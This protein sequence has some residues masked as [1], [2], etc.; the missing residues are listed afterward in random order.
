MCVGGWVSYHIPLRLFSLLLT[1]STHT[2][3]L[4]APSQVDAQ[5]ITPHSPKGFHHLPLLSSGLHFRRGLPDGYEPRCGTR[6]HIIKAGQVDFIATPIPSHCHPPDRHAHLLLLHIQTA[7]TYASGTDGDVEIV[8]VAKELHFSIVVYD[9]AHTPKNER[10]TTHKMIAALKFDSLL[11][12][13]ATPMLNHCRDN[14]VYLRLAF[15]DLPAMPVL[16]PGTDPA[17]LYREDWDPYSPPPAK[18]TS[19]PSKKFVP[20]DGY[21]PLL[22]RDAP[23]GSLRHR[24]LTAFRDR[25]F[26][27]WALSPRL[28]RT[29]ARRHGWNYDSQSILESVLGLD[30]SSPL[31]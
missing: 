20:E 3:D 10:S 28:F 27:W 7:S 26:G 18:P 4:S 12:S 31:V 8:N 24:L 17:D 11:L 30:G 1:L 22:S 9:K 13:S 16:P 14:L 2:S 29:T 19:S 21:K 15:W 23:A 25:S 6:R 5:R